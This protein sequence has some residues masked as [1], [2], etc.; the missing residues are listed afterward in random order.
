MWQIH[1]RTPFAAAQSWVRN[2]DGAET[3]IVVVKATFDIADDGFTSISERQPPPTRT[4]VYRGEPGRSSIEYENDFVLA[5]TTTDI[6]VNGTACAPSGRPLSSVDVAFK[7][8]P[9]AKV[10]RVTGDRSWRMA[11]SGLSDPEPFLTMPL[12]YERA[13]GVADPRSATPE[14]DWYWSNPVGTGFAVSDRDLSAIRVP[15]I[16]YPDDPIRSLKARPRPA[17]FGVIG[18]HWQ[19]RARYA[20]TYDKA[21][22]DERQPLLPADFDLRHYQVVAR[23]QQAPRFLSGGEP[24]S[25]VNLTPSGMLRFVL[26]R[27][28]VTLETRFMDDEQRE[29][30]PQLHTVILE[31]DFPRVSLVWHSAIEYPAA[32]PESSRYENGRASLR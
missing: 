3:W 32:L 14:V 11:G 1:N 22:A 13:F 12:T 2:L 19:E 10:L 8:G 28:E 27:L 23:D 29:H 25:L 30:V 15:N 20:G 6:V 9:V 5:K 21:W 16:E 26:P 4:P 17:G 24:V 18:P 31:P 7:V